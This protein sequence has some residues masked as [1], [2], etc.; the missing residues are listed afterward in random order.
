[1]VKAASSPEGQILVDGSGRTLYL[2]QADTGPTSTCNGACAAAWPPDTT[3]GAPSGTGVNTALLGTSA[4]ADH[5]TQVTYKGHPLYY[6]ADDA[7]PGQTN[8]QGV[9]AFGGRWYVVGPGGAAITAMPT[10]PSPS[11]GGGGGNGY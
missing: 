5:A 6:F 3:S 9:D 1:M 4:R 7:K 8:G 11:P 2:F 10:T